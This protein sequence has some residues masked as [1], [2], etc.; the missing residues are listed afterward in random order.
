M[1]TA[2]TRACV[3]L[4]VLALAAPACTK[5]LED[6]QEAWTENRERIATLSATYPSFEAPLKAQL[7]AAEAIHADAQALSDPEKKTEKLAEA[8]RALKGGLAKT[9]SSLDDDLDRLEAQARQ[10]R[11]RARTESDRVAARLASEAARDAVREA[12]EQLGAELG[13]VAEARALLARVRREVSKAKDDLSSVRRS[14]QRDARERRRARREDREERSRPPRRL[15]IPSAPS[16]ARVPAARAKDRAPA[17]AKKPWTC[18]Y[19]DSKNDPKHLKC[20][21]CGASRP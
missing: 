14:I 21:S 8:N 1:R 6:E 12:R 4:A 7:K 11:S 2:F 9:L 13:D 20:Q 15:E 17:R 3:L 16:K 19:C 10:V 5:S 18:A